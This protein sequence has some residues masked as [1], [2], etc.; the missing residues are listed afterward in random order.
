MKKYTKSE[1]E[2]IVNDENYFES[3]FSELT[4][5]EQLSF[6]RSI[7]KIKSS[8]SNYDMITATYKDSEEKLR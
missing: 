6:L 3:I 7:G 2:E 5:K 4:P 1:I 8:F